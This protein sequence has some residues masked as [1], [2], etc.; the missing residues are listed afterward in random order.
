MAATVT[1]TALHLA[2]DQSDASTWSG[3]KTCQPEPARNAHELYESATFA[4]SPTEALSAAIASS[5]NSLAMFVSMG[6]N[7][8]ARKHLSLLL[9]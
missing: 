3:R 9:R 5:H 4:L 8:P 7:F 2:M 6:E 1:Y